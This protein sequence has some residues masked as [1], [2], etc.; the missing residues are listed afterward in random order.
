MKNTQNT[1]N[2]NGGFYTYKIPK[3]KMLHSARI[4]KPKTKMNT[5][6]K[7]RFLH[8][9]NTN[10][11]NTGFCKKKKLKRKKEILHVDNIH[12]KKGVSTCIKHPKRNPGIDSTRIK[13]AKRKRPK[14]ELYP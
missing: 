9:E 10:K 3:M 6:C 12:T 4:P 5:K 14:M 7:F 2:D 8:V 1:Q 11:E 13:L